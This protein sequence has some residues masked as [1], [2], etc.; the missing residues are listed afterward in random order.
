VNSRGH[1]SARLDPGAFRC[2]VCR[3][4]VTGTPSG[5]CPRCGFVPPA[6]P[7]IAAEPRR[8]TPWTALAMIVA[9]AFAIVLGQSL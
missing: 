1:V 3:I 4:Y 7:A 9:L 2:L 8:T 6:A 5:H